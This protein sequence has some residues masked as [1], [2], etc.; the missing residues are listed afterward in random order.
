MSAGL[1]GSSTSS[2]WLTSNS[3]IRSIAF[4]AVRKQ[5]G[6]L[7]FRWR[8]SHGGGSAPVM[9]TFQVSI[10]GAGRGRGRAGAYGTTCVGQGGAGAY[11][12]LV[13]ILIGVHIL[14]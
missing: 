2:M 1:R 9:A 14:D 11:F 12:R 8:A 10:R 6:L 7:G 3:P 4:G 5:V 13:H